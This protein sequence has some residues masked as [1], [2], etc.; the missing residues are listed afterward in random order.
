MGH[1]PHLYLP[2]PWQAESIPLSGQQLS[3]LRKSLR[4][5]DPADVTYTDGQGRVGLGGFDGAAV[6]RGEEEA[7]SR[8]AVIR[9]AVAP[10]RSKDRQRFLVEKLQEIGVGAISWLRTEHGT[11]GVPAPRRAAAWAVG[12]LEQSRGAW[13]M[14]IEGESLL[15]DYDKSSLVVCDQEGVSI[16]P[17]AAAI[18]AIGP[19]G[20]WAPGEIAPEFARWSLGRTVLRVE[21]AAIVAAARLI[22]VHGN[23]G[24]HGLVS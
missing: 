7:I 13:L 16:P 9:I 1:R 23:G 17:P 14:E 15:E 24:R 10:P 20:G 21:T 5:T 19:E 8:G 2:G 11:G 4:I 3:H 18:V 6:T 22:N 12:A